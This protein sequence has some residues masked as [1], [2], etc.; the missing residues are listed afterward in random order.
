M[1]KQLAEFESYINQHQISKESL[2][3]ASVGWHVHHCLTVINGVSLSLMRSK[4]VDYVS[5]F[6]LIK[7]YVF[8]I[9]KFPRGKSKAPKNATPPETITEEDIRKQLKNAHKLILKIEALPNKSHFKHAIFGTL[10]LKESIKFLKL[11]NEH[12]L[13]I[14][15]DILK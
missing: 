10:N 7:L 14:I 6:N 15:R 13:K 8:L 5:K 1:E 12:H 4:E 2:S 9:K 3:K 11:H